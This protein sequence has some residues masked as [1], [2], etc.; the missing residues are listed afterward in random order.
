MAP[1]KKRLGEIL[2]DAGVLDAGKL[3]SALAE[4]RRWGG[5]LGRT[6]VEMGYVDEGSMI[7]A[8]S[9]QL[10]IPAVDLDERKPNGNVAQWLKAELAEKYSVFPLACDRR[11]KTLQLAT[12]D[13]TNYEAER[14]LTFHTGMRIQL[15]LAGPKA[16]EKA[17]RKHY[18]GEDLGA[19]T[20]PGE[21]DSGPKLQLERTSHS[22]PKLKPPTPI[23]APR[24]PSSGMSLSDEVELLSLLGPLEKQMKT[25][26]KAVR[27]IIDLLEEKG[28]LRRGEV[29]GKLKR[30]SED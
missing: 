5:R 8:L 25:Q 28:H 10:G 4:Q 1:A 16:I 30:N 29:D 13:P 3:Q 15:A 12:S 2:I 23:A 11:Q 14:E 21:G 7:F 18:H 9:R 19:V 6:L 27:A 26:T 24:P 20:S 22:L 17:I